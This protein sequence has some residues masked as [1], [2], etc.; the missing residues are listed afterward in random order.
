VAQADHHHLE[1]QQEL[2]RILDHLL[3]QMGVVEVELSTQM[4]Q[5]EHLDLVVV[6]VVVLLVDKL[7]EQELQVKETQ[8][9]L[10]LE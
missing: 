8:V 7:L 9:E 1:E 3:L 5:L 2:H 10:V 6:L 4:H